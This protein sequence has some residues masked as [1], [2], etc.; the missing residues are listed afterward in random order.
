MKIEELDVSEECRDKFRGSGIETADDIV[1]FFQEVVGN[2]TVVVSWGGECFEEV[3]AK[4]KL[5]GLLPEDF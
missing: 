4:F 5:M 1:E 2:A 3:V